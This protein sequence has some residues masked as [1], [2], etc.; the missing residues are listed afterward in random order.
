ML[1]KRR[2]VLGSSN[3]VPGYG[4]KKSKGYNLKEISKMMKILNKHKISFIDTASSY[5]GV[6]KKI[7]QSGISNFKVFTKIPELLNNVTI[8][9]WMKKCIMRSR[10]RTKKKFFEGIFFHNPQDLLTANG[11]TLYNSLVELKKEGFTRKIGVSVYSPKELKKILNKYSFDMVQ[12]PIN[13][14]DRRFLQNNYL[15]LLKKKKIEIHARSIF[16]QGIL[17]LDS[18][19]MPGYFLT[20]KNLFNRWSKWNER[21]KLTKLQT[22]LNFILNLKNIDKVVIGV[23]NIS[24]LEEILKYNQYK[25]KIFPKKIFSTNQKLIDPR[26]WK[27]N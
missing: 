22:C 12:I 1:N 11:N 5:Y 9:S 8:K 26:Q 23:E 3:F 16:L 18:Y 24:Q 27:K 13:I 14:F 6:E 2:L 15:N 7:G 17:L 25:K 20:W 19:S 21:N 4:I 10:L